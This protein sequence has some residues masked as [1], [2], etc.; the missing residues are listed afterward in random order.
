MPC[1]PDPKLVM[2]T[3]L[4]RKKQTLSFSNLELTCCVNAVPG[5]PWLIVCNTVVVQCIMDYITNGLVSGAFSYCPLV[6]VKDRLEMDKP[7]SLEEEN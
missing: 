6:N 2:S 5:N 7:V 4:C 3:G 1:L